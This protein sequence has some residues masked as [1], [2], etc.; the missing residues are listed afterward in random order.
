MTRRRVSITRDEVSGVI[1]VCYLGD[2]I[3]VQAPYRV[4]RV[5]EGL[6]TAGERLWVDHYKATKEFDLSGIDMLIDV[7]ANIGE[8]SRYFLDMGK[9]VIAFEPDPVCLKCLT[10]NLK[11]EAIIVGQALS[12]QVEISKLFLSTENADTSLINPSLNC[13]NVETTTLKIQLTSYPKESL[14]RAILKMDAEGWEPE[15]LLGAK[16]KLREIGYLVIDAEAERL[17]QFTYEQCTEI[18]KANGFMVNMHLK[19]GLIYAI[20]QNAESI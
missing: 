16:E 19:E 6:T 8:L 9:R 15:V 18:L 4:L 11:D 17:G 13:I 20:N 14:S 1:T 7:G 12:D 2:Q 5:R 3:K 10:I